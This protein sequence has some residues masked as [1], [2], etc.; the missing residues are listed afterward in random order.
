METVEMNEFN[1]RPEG[2]DEAEEG[3][4]ETVIVEDDFLDHLDQTV[5]GLNEA[6]ASGFR[7]ENKDDTY[8]RRKEQTNKL[9][10]TGKFN[11]IKGEFARKLLSSEYRIDPTDGQNSR[12]FISRLDITKHKL[13][14]DGTVIGYID[15]SGAF[16]MSRNKKSAGSMTQF[17]KLYEKALIKHKKGVRS[18]VEEETGGDMLEENAE[19][20]YEDAEEEFHRDVVNASDKLAEQAE[21]LESEG[22]ITE[23]ERK[24]F[25]G[26]TAPKGPPKGRIKHIDIIMKERKSNIEKETDDDRRQITQRAVNVAEQA[27]DDARLE[28]GQV[29]RS[30]EGKHRYRKIVRDNTRTK[31]ERFRVWAKENMGALAAIAI[32]IAGIITTVVVAG[33]K[34]ITGAANGLGAA[35]KALAK[36]AKAAL[37]ILVPILNMLS[38][39][40]GWGAKG[41]A[42]L[43]QNLRIVAIV[44]TGAI[45]RY[46]QNRR[47]KYIYFCTIIKHN[48]PNG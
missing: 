21:R 28:M 7:E 3:E 38:T 23:Q 12:E 27:I 25:A 1:D 37:P 47:K 32:S 43:A 33:K 46:L 29:P 2:N 31:F 13:T 9:Y 34:T 5:D 36:F 20:I 35:G 4:D 39:I 14:F 45:F 24:E 8:R 48:E 16:R 11:D 10:L 44:I 6:K 40:L 15:T 42:F 22:K 19:E 30:E 26:I 41:L 17:K 18:V